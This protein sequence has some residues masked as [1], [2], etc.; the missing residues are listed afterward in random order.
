MTIWLSHSHPVTGEPVGRRAYWR[1]MQIAVDIK[2]ELEKQGVIHPNSDPE[3]VRLAV[4]ARFE[5]C[6]IS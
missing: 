2:A 6:Q 4:K 3:I 5:Q 1:S